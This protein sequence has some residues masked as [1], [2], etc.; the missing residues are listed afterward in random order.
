MQKESIFSK[1][2]LKKISSPEELNQL[3]HVTGPMA[4]IA[5]M[6]FIML[7]IAGIFWCI[8][9]KIPMTVHGSG[10]LMR[11]HGIIEAISLGEGQV[12]SV[13]FQLGEEV[14]KG[15]VLVK[16]SQPLLEDKAKVRQEQ[17][18]RLR[19]LKKPAREDLR[20][21]EELRMSIEDITR[22]IGIK[23][24]V[25]SPASGVVIQRLVG[26]GDYM[27]TGQTVADIEIPSEE[28]IYIMF[29]PVSEGEDIQP[30]MRVEISP[31]IASK[32]EY[33]FMVGKVKYVSLY[34]Q[35]K[36]SLMRFLRNEQ[37]AEMFSAEGP[38]LAVYIELEKN[39]GTSG[40]YKWSSSRVPKVFI[41]SG[42]LCTST[43][44]L[45]EVHP[46][47]LVFAREE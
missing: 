19:S 45:K 8:A 17:L 24:F 47:S 39:P 22:E 12:E 20:L 35:R 11:S 26:M 33:G 23:S 30:G 10:I 16:I 34:P 32:K 27:N 5:L 38:P 9:G 25:H 6:A 36:Q 14:E 31:E 44:M 21:I 1:R 15:Q 37:L 41:Q 3:M 7:V 4:W 18:S 43:V 29:I 42:T 13:Y 28:L 2:A 40:G 46:I